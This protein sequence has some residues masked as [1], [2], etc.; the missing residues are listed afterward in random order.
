[1]GVNDWWKHKSYEHTR[2]VS[3]AMTAR[4][5]AVVLAIVFADDRTD[6]ADLLMKVDAMDANTT[7]DDHALSLMQYRA[8]HLT[9]SDGTEAR[10]QNRNEQQDGKL[11]AVDLEDPTAPETGRC[12]AI[13]IHSLDLTAGYAAESTARQSQRARSSTRSARIIPKRQQQ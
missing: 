5:F 6:L 13:A 12:R 11:A 1:V 9:F 7:H 2:F 4:V 8:Y 3:Y 10:D